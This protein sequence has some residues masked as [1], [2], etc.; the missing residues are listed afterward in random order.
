MLHHLDQTKIKARLDA[1]TRVEGDCVVWT[2]SLK[3][4]GYGQMFLGR[5]PQGRRLIWMVHRVSYMLA[6]QRDPGDLCVCHR[7]D[8][9]R[10]VK[11]EHLFLGTRADN[12]R[13]MFSK[14]RGNVLDGSLARGALN[15]NAKLTAGA[16]EFIR[17]NPSMAL[18]ALASRYG[19]TKQAVWHVRQGKTWRKSGHADSQDAG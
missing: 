16:V 5:D 12:N 2:G 1:K 13:D 4:H 10:C 6:N 3:H 14:G 15:V 8:N 18:G 7:C 11:P 17:A 19:V 9:R